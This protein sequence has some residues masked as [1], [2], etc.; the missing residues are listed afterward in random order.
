MDARSIAL[1]KCYSLEGYAELP[2]E[3]K[4]RIYDAIMRATNPDYSGSSFYSVKKHGKTW[5]FMPEK[6][7]VMYDLLD[8]LKKYDPQD[9]CGMI[10]AEITYHN[11]WTSNGILHEQRYHVRRVFRRRQNNGDYKYHT[12][13]DEKNFLHIEQE[14]IVKTWTVPIPPWEWQC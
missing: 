1:K 13:V 4:N 9:P 8:S 10:P 3:D 5:Y 6:K 14:G 12:K 2:M 11:V 7:H